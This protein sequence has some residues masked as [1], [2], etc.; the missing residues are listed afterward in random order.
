MVCS[1]CSNADRTVYADALKNLDDWPPKGSF[2][3]FSDTESN[4]TRLAGRSVSSCGVKVG[5]EALHN[6]RLEAS[7][8]VRVPLTGAS[9]RSSSKPLI[10]S[11]VGCP[12]ACGSSDSRFYQAAQRSTAG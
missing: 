7:L 6:Y 9:I 4:N 8:I 2:S 12:V 11:K 3:R 1:A 5:L 10:F